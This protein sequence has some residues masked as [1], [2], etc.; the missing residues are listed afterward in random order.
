[1]KL[2]DLLERKGKIAVTVPETANIALAIQTMHEHRVGAVMVPSAS[3]KPLGI[4]SDRDVVRY[5]ARGERD[6]E[7][8]LV[9][10]YMTTEVVVGKPSDRVD[11]V[12]AIMTEKRFRHMPVI[13]NNRIIGVVSIGDLVKCKLEETTEEAQALREY[14]NS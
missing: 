10:D 14:I 1:M 2:I 11:D 5:Y 13:E 6:F 3:G 8:M 7:A 4:L 12:M 9:K